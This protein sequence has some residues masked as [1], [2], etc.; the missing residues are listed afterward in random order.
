MNVDCDFRKWKDKPHWRFPAEVIERDAFGTWLG[1]LPPTPFTGPR[2]AG[3]WEHAFAILVP[4]S[5]W[6]I[7]T[8]NEERHEG[9]EIY[10]DICTP[11]EWHTPNHFSSIDLDLD[12]IRMRDGTVYLDDE[13]EFLEHQVTFGYPPDVVENVSTTAQRVM[14]LVTARTEPFGTAGAEKLAHL[15][16]Q[17]YDTR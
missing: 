7:A 5:D 8:F 14:D 1:A 15:L 13:D 16:Q 6:W 9:V 10:I 17:P 3:E 12:V 2:G 11:A 4:A